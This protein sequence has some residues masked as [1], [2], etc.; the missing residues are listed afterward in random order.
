[1]QIFPFRPAVATIGITL[2]LAALACSPAQGTRDEAATETTPNHAWPPVVGERYPDLQLMDVRGERISLSSLAGRVILLEPVGMDCPACQ[3]FAGA[4]RPEVGSFG[5]VRP[6]AG[7]P[8]VREMLEQYAHV[9]P[10]DDRLVYVQLL[11][12]DMKRAGAPTLDVAR[13]WAEHFGIADLPD[14]YVLVG[15]PYLIGPASFRM[16]PGFQLI[17]RDFVLRY[18]AGGHHPVHDLWRELMPAVGGLLEQ[19][20]APGS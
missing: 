18:D 1:M 17:D 2:C 3:G 6:Q 5:D 12:Y 8:E 11:L 9:D 4:N 7:L 16:I 10:Y 20:G 14:T 15:E 19:A 13:R